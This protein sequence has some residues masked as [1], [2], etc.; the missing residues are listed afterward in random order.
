MAARGL[1]ASAAGCM[2]T[3]A[4]VSGRRSL[5]TSTEFGESPEAMVPGGA[6]AGGGGDADEVVAAP[7][8][9]RVA[10]AGDGCGQPDEA[11]RSGAFD[12]T[13]DSG[14]AHG[15]AGGCGEAQAA[16]DGS[17]AALS[18]GVSAACAQAERSRFRNW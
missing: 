9:T 17:A 6:V 16:A 4:P 2:A 8:Q 14:A 3:G 12:A 13:V 5:S 11:S 10:G 7:S 1:S 15:V 18:S